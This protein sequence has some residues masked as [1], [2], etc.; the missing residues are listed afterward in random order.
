MRV[1]ESGSD[2][3]ILAIDYF[4]FAVNGIDHRSAALETTDGDD[5]ISLNNN[6]ARKWRIA[7]AIDNCCPG[8][9]D[10]SSLSHGR[11]S[12]RLRLHARIAIRSTK[13][14][15]LLVYRNQ[16]AAKKDHY[17]ACDQVKR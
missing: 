1:Y 13:A 16:K 9:K 12:L 3:A 6:F 15:S 8:Q 14:L 2:D 4:V 7:G 5:P 10:A 11:M 17:A